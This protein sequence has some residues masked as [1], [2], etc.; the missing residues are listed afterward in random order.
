MSK[1]EDFDSAPASPADTASNVSESTKDLSAKIETDSELEDNIS[2]SSWR[3][4]TLI[5]ISEFIKR[6]ASNKSDKIFNP[7]I[8]AVIDSKEYTKANKQTKFTYKEIIKKPLSLETLRNRVESGQIANNM[9]LKR[10]F[11]LMLVNASMFYKNAD[12][13]VRSKLLNLLLA[14]N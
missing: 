5:F 3:K 1:S 12:S 4:Q 7:D 11:V 10:D 9:E 13:E 14:Q 2:D 6:F 8:S